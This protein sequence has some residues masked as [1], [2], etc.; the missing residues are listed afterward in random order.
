MN[1][2]HGSYHNK[3]FLRELLTS[4]ETLTPMMNPFGFI[5]GIFDNLAS[6]DAELRD[7]LTYRLFVRIIHEK[8]LLTPP[9]IREVLYTALDDENT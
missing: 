1:I 4:D 5:M 3:V 7:E 8:Q 6:P 9:Q 2:E